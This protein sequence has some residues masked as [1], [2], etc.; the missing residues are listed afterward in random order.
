MF[1]ANVQN[2]LLW[3]VPTMNRVY[4]YFF[5]QI[6]QKLVVSASEPNFFCPI[7]HYCY[8]QLS[9]PFLFKVYKESLSEGENIER[10][11][12]AVVTTTL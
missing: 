4:C 11:V 1:A 9:F 6:Q 12:I 10:D 7:V 2:M 8:V 5:A 3:H